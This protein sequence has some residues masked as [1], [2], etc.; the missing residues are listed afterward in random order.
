MKAHIVREAFGLDGKDYH[1]GAEITDPAVLEKV[2]GSHHHH[3]HVIRLPHDAAPA[4][5]DDKPSEAS[6]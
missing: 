2:L 3:H 6:K 5:K 1:R 4:A